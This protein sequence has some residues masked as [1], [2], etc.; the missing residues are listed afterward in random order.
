MHASR[1]RESIARCGQHGRYRA[2]PGGLQW[3]DENQENCGGG[4]G[5]RTG[6]SSGALKNSVSEIDKVMG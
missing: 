3:L 4:S 6:C 2:W 5:M 1:L